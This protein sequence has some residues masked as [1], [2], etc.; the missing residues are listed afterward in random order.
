MPYVDGVRNDVIVK[1]GHDMISWSNL[2]EVVPEAV[3]AFNLKAGLTCT[4]A[5]P[6]TLT[7]SRVKMYVGP[8][9]RNSGVKTLRGGAWVGQRAEVNR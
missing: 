8:Y 5:L 2:T 6:K 9:W 1:I 7:S 3:V 4:T